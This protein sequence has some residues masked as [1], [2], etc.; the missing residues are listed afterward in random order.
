[1]TCYVFDQ[2]L[3]G[4]INNQKWDQKVSDT[5]RIVETPDPKNDGVMKQTFTPVVCQHDFMRKFKA[6]INTPHDPLTLDG[7]ANHWKTKRHLTSL[8]NEATYDPIN[9]KLDIGSWVQR[10]VET[11]EIQA[12]L[13]EQLN[14]KVKI[15]ESK[16]P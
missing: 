5:Y 1:M 6:R 14:Q 8:P 9:N 12:V 11:V 10:L 16:V 4:T 2:A 13:I 15:L 3:D 7:Y